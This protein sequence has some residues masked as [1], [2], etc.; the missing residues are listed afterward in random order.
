MPNIKFTIDTIVTTPFKVDEDG[1]RTHPQPGEWLIQLIDPKSDNQAVL[2]DYHG[3]SKSTTFD[4]TAGDTYNIKAARL[5][6]V[7][8]II[9]AVMLMNY[10]VGSGDIEAVEIPS[11]ISVA[12]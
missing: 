3:S 7:G 1:V 2:Y 6:T 8:N 4:L 10:V 11:A 5:D 9:S 12:E